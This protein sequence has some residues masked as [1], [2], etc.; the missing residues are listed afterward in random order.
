MEVWAQILLKK[1]DVWAKILEKHSTEIN[2]GVVIHFCNEGNIKAA[3]QAAH[4]EQRQKLQQ[5][6]EDKYQSRYP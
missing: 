6:M 5:T 1:K 4:Q 2:L 3:H